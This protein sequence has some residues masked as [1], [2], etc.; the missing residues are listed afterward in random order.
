VN[1]NS[2]STYFIDANHLSAQSDVLVADGIIAFLKE[3][4]LLN[5]HH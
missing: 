4:K 3:Q 2:K 1:G 5:V